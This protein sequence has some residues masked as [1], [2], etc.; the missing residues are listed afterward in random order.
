MASVTPK[1]RSRKH[2][3][4][5]PLDDFDRRLLNQMQGAFPIEPRPYA[6]VAARARA[7]PRSA[8]S[9]ACRS[10]LDERII[11][12]V[13]PIFDTRALGYGS[14]LVA[15][16][17]D[18][19]HPWRAAT[20]RQRRTPASRTTTCATTTSTCGS[21]SPSSRGLAARA[22]RHARRSCRSSPAPSRSASCRRSS[23]SRSAW[24]SRWRAA[25]TRSPGPARPPWSRSSSTKQPYDELDQAVI[26]ATQGDLPV[27]PE[28]YAPAAARARRV[29]RRARRAPRAAWST[30]VC[31][32]ASRRSSSTG[33]RASAPTAWASGAS[34]TTACSSS[35]RGWPRSAA[36][37][38][39]TS[40][41]PTPT[42]PT[43]S[44]RWPTGAP[45][46]S[47][48]RSSTR[49]PSEIDGDRGAR[50]ALQLH[51]V[52]EDPPALLHRRLQRLGARARRRDAAS[53]RAR[54]AHRR[55]VR[56]AL[57][58]G[59]AAPARRRQLAGAGDAGDRARPDLHRAR[60][61]RGDRRRRRQPLRRLRAARGARSIHGHAHPDVL[62]AVISAAA[63]G[64]TFGAPTAGEVDLAEEIARRVPG[65][66]DGA[67]DLLGDRGDD[68]RDPPRPRRDRA[69]EASE[70]R[71][72]LPR[73]RR[74]PARPGGLGA[75]HGRDPV[76]PRR[77]RGRHRERRSSCGWNDAEAVSAATER[78]RVRRDPR[79]ALPGQHGPRRRRRPGF[80]ELLR[81]R[82]TATGALLVFDEVI[83]G[84]RVARGG[85][86]ELTGVVPDLTVMGKVIGGGLP[87]AAL[88]RPARAHGAP[89]AGR[90]RLPGGHAERAT[91][92]RSPPGWRPCACSTTPPT[93]TWPRRPRAWPTGSVEPPR[94]RA[95]PCR[96]SPRPA[97]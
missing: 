37:R 94:P 1:L 31:C 39:A 20:G 86:Q 6:A 84:F 8:C 76:E 97:C 5:I 41:R 91:R 56:R 14:M 44:S 35:A 51:G 69:R 77:A 32:G 34:P 66:R 65:G 9:G 25:R 38:T 67:H 93:R 81:E 50:D 64:T 88:R 68:E 87:A 15:A 47:A 4:A 43:R 26:R 83:T 11:R 95:C 75:R 72:R 79:R 92:S 62:A 49:S 19:E 45:R 58:P 27:V 73:P 90:R 48:T 96:S 3:A 17:V 42:G 80:L 78:A 40:A 53:V 46:R 63:R 29:R 70:V 22:R 55:E 7:C 57:P 54:L 30:A 89:R 28:P 21:R 74:R 60:R 10:S 85:A 52:Q 13:T 36:S 16:K 82:A 61:G 24:T 23:S 12:Q 18:P 59:A 33:A 2:G 71:G